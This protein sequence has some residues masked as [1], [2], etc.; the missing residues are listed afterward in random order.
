[1][2][3]PS[4]SLTIACMLSPREYAQRLR[5]FRRLFA[6]SL[7]D[8]R[9][10]PRLLHLTLSD[11]PGREEATRDLLRREQE[12]CPFF[13]FDVVAAAGTVTTAAGGPGGGGT[14]P[15]AFG[16]RPGGARGGGGGWAP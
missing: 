3:V 13:T 9:R 7:A 11:A 1:M 6:D 2:Q 15:G 16:R 5:E 4:D 8:Y 10:A 12:C 14:R